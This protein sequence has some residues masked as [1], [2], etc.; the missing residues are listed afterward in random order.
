M[1]LITLSGYPSSGKTR[2]AI[3]LKHYLDRRLADSPHTQNVV[4]LS[5]DSVN[6]D[7][8]S[9][10]GAA[11]IPYTCFALDRN[12]TIDSRSEKP[13]R[14]TL[15]A[16]AQRQM[17]QGTI[18]IIDALN[19]IKGFRY[20]LYCAAREFKLRVCTVG[21]HVSPIRCLQRLTLHANRSTSLLLRNYA[22]DG[23][24]IGR[25]A[26]DIVLRRRCQFGC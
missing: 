15:F 14:A 21:F 8:S 6:I 19:Y 3:Q 5:D 17:G 1:A 23:T 24:V 9:Y 4:L 16:A 2:R 26:T 18:L 22:S 25:M 12:D 7:R 10:D 13:A 20:Q 11:V